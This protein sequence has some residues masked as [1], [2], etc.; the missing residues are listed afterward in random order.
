MATRTSRSSAAKKESAPAPESRG[1][2]SGDLRRMRVSFPEA[3]TSTNEWID[4]QENLSRS[5]QVL[6]RESIM[7][8]G[9][10]DVVNRPVGQMP[11]R[12][13]PPL[14]MVQA[15][16]ESEPESAEESCHDDFR[17]E[18]AKPN[19]IVMSR[20][21][22][23]KR[24]ST[25]AAEPEQTKG[26]DPHGPDLV[27]QVPDA[28]ELD[29]LTGG[30]PGPYDPLAHAGSADEPEPAAPAPAEPAPQSPSG[31]VDIDDIFG[32]NG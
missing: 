10:L 17:L 29:L 25:E 15:R 9:Y 6:I 31:Q 1:P 12:G 24:L 3:D 20:A 11:R 26:L 5:L 7:R 8:D 32:H 4:R 13:R 22:Q 14:E 16:E 28:E 18:G 23:G 19:T 2:R 27:A 21:T 30:A